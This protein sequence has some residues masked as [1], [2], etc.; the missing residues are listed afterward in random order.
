[1]DMSNV[2]RFDGHQKCENL[3]L[4]TENAKLNCHLPIKITFK[5]LNFSVTE[6]KKKPCGKAVETKH[7]I[8]KPMSGYAMPGTTTYIMGASGSGK[9][10][11]LNLISDR[12]QKRKGVEFSGEIKFND[13]VPVNQKSFGQVGSYVM[14]DD[15]L[16]EYFTVKEALTFAARLRLK[17]PIAEQD[18]RVDALIQ[19]LGLYNSQNT[20]CG[21]QMRKTISGGERKRTSIGVEMITDPSIIFLDEPTS[22]LD[23]FRATSI[24]MLLSKLAHER[25][26]TVIA[27]IHSPNSSAYSYFD[28]LILL[29]DGHMVYQ[30]TAHEGTNYL[31][32]LG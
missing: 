7:Q 31:K 8:L 25:G 19:D 27:T 9:T 26:K 20:E 23:S 5:D 4:H 10:S 15:I 24:V 30:G 12:I 13:K 6:T 2:S 16:F 17:I 29:C 11:L 14:Q 22:G 32:K 18:A 21:S 1:M 3:D 28:R